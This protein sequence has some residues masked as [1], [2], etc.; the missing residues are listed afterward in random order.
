MRKYLILIPFILTFWAGMVAAISFLEAWLKFQAEGVTLKIGLG[1]GQLVY[2]A[3]NWIELTF[4]ALVWVMIAA[5]SRIQSGR[6][7]YQYWMLCGLTLILMLQSV[8]LLPELNNR[9]QLIIEGTHP[10]RSTIHLWY[11]IFEFAKFILLIVLAIIMG[12]LNVV[13]IENE[14]NEE[15]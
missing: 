1:I 13:S 6:M 4:M 10:V 7:T 3:L 11:V 2:G 15:I 5:F 12:S 8:W 14:Q 9:A